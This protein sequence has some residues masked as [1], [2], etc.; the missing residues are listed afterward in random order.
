MDVSHVPSEVLGQYVDSAML[1]AQSVNNAAVHSQS[2]ITT[3]H[4]PYSG[5][6]WSEKMLPP[7][8]EENQYLYPEFFVQDTVPLQIRPRSSECSYL[9]SGLKGNT[10]LIHGKI[11]HILLRSCEA[12]SLDIKGGTVSGVDIL[13]SANMLVRLPRHNHTNLEY[14]EGVHFTGEVDDVSQIHITGSLDVRING[15]GLPLNPFMN[16][17]FTS[18]GCYHKTRASVPQLSLFST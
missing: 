18:A 16:V 5:C 11:N 6:N 10:V 8:Q 3:V 9:L 14:G 1:T 7:W 12:L 2:L 15:S 4:G 17:V 13:H